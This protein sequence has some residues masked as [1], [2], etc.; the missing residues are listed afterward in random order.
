MRSPL[1]STKSVKQIANETEARLAKDLGG[2][3]VPA[4]GA[5]DGAKGDVSTAD[6]LIDSKQTGAA[7]IIVSAK[8]LNKITKEAREANR[9][10]ALKLQLEGIQLGVAKEWMLIPLHVFKEI[11]REHN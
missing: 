10:P 5:L 4:S 3:T 7:S 9:K 8:Q 2:R 11:T 1:K 6:F